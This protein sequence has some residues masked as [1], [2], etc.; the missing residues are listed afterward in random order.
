MFKI[1]KITGTVELTSQ[2]GDQ[3]DLYQIQTSIGLDHLATPAECE[4]YLRVAA[5]A[6]I[7]ARDSSLSNP[8]LIGAVELEVSQVVTEILGE[9]N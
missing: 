1:Y 2:C 9:L 6:E 4:G 8:I 3:L 7:S 5:L